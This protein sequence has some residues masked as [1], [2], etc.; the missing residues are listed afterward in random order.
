M[1]EFYRGVV[2]RYG[3]LDEEQKRLVRNFINTDTGQLVAF[4]L[5]PEMAGLVTE[6]QTEAQQTQ[7]EPEFL[8][9]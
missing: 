9:G 5:G 7:V 6:L 8:R 1:D 3:S 4:I 2:E